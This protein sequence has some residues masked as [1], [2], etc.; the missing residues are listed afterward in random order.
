AGCKKI[1]IQIFDFSMDLVKNI[2][3]DFYKPKW[4]GT[5]EDGE[6]VAGGIYF[7]RAEVDGKVSWGKIVII[8]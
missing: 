7:F 3:I 1:K 2:P 8:N 6:Q 4:D 5:T